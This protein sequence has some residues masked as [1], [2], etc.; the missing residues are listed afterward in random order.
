[1]DG[2]NQTYMAERAIIHPFGVTLDLATKTVYW[3]DSYM[4]F[5]YAIDYWGNFK[6]RNVAKGF[7]VQ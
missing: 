6:R 7:K 1:M 2:S 5:V 3:L 4:E